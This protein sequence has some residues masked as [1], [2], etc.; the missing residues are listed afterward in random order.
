MRTTAP[1]DPTNAGARLRASAV[2][3][4][5]PTPAPSSCPVTCW[6]CGADCEWRETFHREPEG[7]LSRSVW[8]GCTHCSWDD[9]RVTEQVG[10]DHPEG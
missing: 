6:R 10:A 3:A 4:P 9:R 1:T 7:V 2:I 8:A 5:R